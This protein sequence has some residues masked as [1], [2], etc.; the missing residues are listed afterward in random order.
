MI[1]EAEDELVNESAYGFEVREGLNQGKASVRR[2][3]NQIQNRLKSLEELADATRLGC[4]IRLVW[5]L[6]FHV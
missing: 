4:K 3:R 1:A 2:V 5:N 6:N